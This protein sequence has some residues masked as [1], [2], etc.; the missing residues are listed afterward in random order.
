M[1]SSPGFGP[2]P[3]DIPEGGALFGLAFAA[4]PQ[5]S[6]L[7][8]ATEIHS[9]A[10]SSIG[11]PSSAFGGLRRFVGTRFQGLLTPLPGCFFTFPSRYF[12]TIGRWKCLALEGGP[13]GFPRDSP[14]PV[15]LKN[16]G[17]GGP[18]PFAYEAFTL[19][20]GPS[21]GPSARAGLGN[22]PAASRL[23]LPVPYNPARALAR[24]PLTS[25]TV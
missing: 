11:T 13:P 4:A 25:L 24:E 5:V 6:L 20:G 12:C 17:Q 19:H 2:N 21:Q 9:P 22:S 3:S 1:G 23:G 15:V 18:R 16:T 8:P 10:H 14:C 7:N